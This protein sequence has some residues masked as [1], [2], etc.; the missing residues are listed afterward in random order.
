MNEE[1]EKRIRAE[2]N[3]LNK[4]L[5][6]TKQK[7]GLEPTPKIKAAKGLIDNA[8][9]MTIH[10]QD[11]QAELNEHG[12]VEEY[13]NG[14]TQYGMKKS[15]AADIYTTMYKNYIATIKQLAE[16]APDNVGTDELSMFMQGGGP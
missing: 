5:G 2:R 12:C 8:A 11:L 6:A 13:R 14:E 15:A 9:F 10:L 1:R 3:R 7:D 16:L 4:I